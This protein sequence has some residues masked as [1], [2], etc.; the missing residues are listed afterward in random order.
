ME[1]Q[2][3]R[4][5]PREAIAISDESWEEL[6]TTRN[7]KYNGGVFIL[8]PTA[9][10][11]K[12]MPT[13]VNIPAI[14]SNIVDSIIFAINAN[15][16]KD[17]ETSTKIFNNT[18]LDISTRNGLRQFMSQQIYLSSAEAKGISRG[19]PRIVFSVADSRIEVY[20][21]GEIKL[22]IDL[23]YSKGRKEKLE[24]LKTYLALQ[25]ITVKSED[26]NSTKKFGVPSIKTNEE[27]S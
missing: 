22:V 18:G 17:T 13:P 20:D 27:V 14:D 26:L 7:N 25:R 4:V 9:V 12:F 19:V 3:N 23:N 21:R 15:I 2:K 24:E 1:R 6:T 11:G 8:V 16:N 10:R 5:Y